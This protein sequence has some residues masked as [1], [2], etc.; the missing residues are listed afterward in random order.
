MS[1]TLPTVLIINGP[2]L[3]LLGVREPE[4]YGTQTLDD[5]QALCE[6]HGKMIGLNVLFYQSNAEGDMVNWIHEAKTLDAGIIINAGA[7]THTSVA[8]LDALL[9]VQPPRLLGECAFEDG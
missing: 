1:D 2:N 8:L 7:Y 3:N 4:T 6:A 5:I 9:A